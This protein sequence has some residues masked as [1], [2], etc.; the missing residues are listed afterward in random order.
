[1]FP[2]PKALLEKRSYLASFHIDKRSLEVGEFAG[3]QD[4][5]AR[6]MLT[7]EWSNGI[8]TASVLGIGRRVEPKP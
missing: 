3:I 6:V 5:D 8:R 7:V 2:P 1:M 4:L